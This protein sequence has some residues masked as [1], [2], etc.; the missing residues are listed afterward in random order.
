MDRRLF[1]KLTGL[2]A[3]GS[4]LGVLPAAAQSV[5]DLPLP[6]SGSPQPELLA[7]GMYQITGR[8]RLQAPQVEISGITNAQQISWSNLGSGS[9]H[10]AGFS[11]FEHFAEPWRMPEI[12]VRGGQLESV[13]V[14]PLELG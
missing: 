4:M 2:A 6:S 5:S 11:S 12:H 3:G 14:T 1:L 7:P 13:A 10:V 9:H 8:V